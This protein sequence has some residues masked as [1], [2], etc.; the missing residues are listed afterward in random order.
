MASVV[1]I[2][3]M[4]LAHLGED[5]SIVSSNPPDATTNAGHCARFY[6]IARKEAL[7]TIRATWSKKRQ[8]LAEVTNPSSIWAYAYALPSDCLTPMRILQQ[9]LVTAL[10]LWPGPGEVLTA[11]DLVLWTERGTADFEVEGEV[12]LCNEP[13][14]VLLYTKEITDTAKFSAK[15]T[16]A[17]SYLLASYLA[18][19]ILKGQPGANAAGQLRKI[20]A[21]VLGEAAVEDANG[22]AGSNDHIPAHIQSR[23]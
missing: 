1:D 13:D 10:D 20:A 11:D 16:V 2:W 12:I 18:G 14:A 22:S 7:E 15:F 21:Q 9:S 19:P 5:A 4:A 6:P 23:R 3:N 17:L 8:L